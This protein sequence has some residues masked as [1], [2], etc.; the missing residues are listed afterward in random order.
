MRYPVSVLV[1]I[2]SKLF[3]WISYLR[4]L[5]LINDYRNH[6]SNNFTHSKYSSKSPVI[7]ME[8]NNMHSSH[9]AYA[10]LGNLL[11][12]KHGGQIKAHAQAS[13][14]NSRQR[15]K[16]K[17]KSILGLAEFGVYKSFGVNEFIELR[18]NKFQ[19]ARARNMY[20][21]VIDRLHNNREIE[22]LHL[23]GVWVGDLF[24]DSFL[25]THKLPTINIS[26]SVFRK[27]LLKSIELFVFWDDYFAKNDVRAINVSHCV[28]NLAIPLRIAVMK[29][30]E[31]YQASLTHIY[32]LNSDNLFAYSKE[33]SSFR[34]QFS[35]LP[36]D[37]RDQGTSLA[38][39]RIKRRFEGE[40]GV[41]MLYS[42]K[43]AY[44]ATRH[45]RLLR[46]SRRKKILIATH[47]FYDS[48]HAFGKNIFPDFYEWIEF[49]GE[50]SELTDYDWY[51]KTHPDYLPGTKDI[52]DKFVL[53]FPKFTLLPSD[54]SHHQI[55]SEG[56]DVALT[57]YG[58]IGFEYAA[59][60]IMVINASQNNQH[61]AYNFNLHARDVTHYR[62][63]LIN[64][65][66]LELIIDPIEI[67]E[68]YFMRYIFNTDDLFF[69]N[70]NQT[71][72]EIGGYYKQFT[73]LI[74]KSWLAEWSDE[75]HRGINNALKDFINSGD[76][77]MNSFNY[78]ADVL[79]VL[80][81]FR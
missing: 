63:M 62:E 80:R 49:L 4:H 57:C 71:I 1:K 11:A 25:M 76:Y 6:N 39:L 40:V 48:P 70:Y 33:F 56:I 54:S 20:E 23:N 67:Y 43:S 37:V 51:I 73:P 14:I 50:I 47:C 78:G 60:G 34:E 75:S 19:R 15:L 35:A 59:L 30:I 18:T 28:Y 69:K 81:G 7:L 52:I 38:K 10:Y 66:R 58:T 41:D 64:L 32:R 46:P 79:A 68:Y 17:L 29:G 8:L 26:S 42:T 5:P 24:Y 12:Q 74:Y 27:F 13:F 16:F 55:V 53:R 61:I 36:L 9:I 2:H 45:N 77:R 22:D 72:L 3:F 44:G 21:D 65:N 31:A